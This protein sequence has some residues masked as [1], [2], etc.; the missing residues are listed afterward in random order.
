MA[1]GGSGDSSGGYGDSGGGHGGHSSG[2]AGGLRTTSLRRG[3][4]GKTVRR[5]ESVNSKK[6]V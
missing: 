1:N 2:R 5:D 3:E 4:D 6:K